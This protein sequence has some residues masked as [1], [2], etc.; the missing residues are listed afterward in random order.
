MSKCERYLEQSADGIRKA[1][2]LWKFVKNKRKN[3]IVAHIGP[4]IW[5]SSY[6]VGELFTLCEGSGVRS[7]SALHSGCTSRLYYCN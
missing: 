7:A 4:V 1:A 2:R 3:D 5:L 6:R